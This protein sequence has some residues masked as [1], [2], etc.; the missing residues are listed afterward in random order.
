[1]KNG[2]ETCEM[3]IMLFDLEEAELLF[4]GLASA[5]SKSH[6]AKEIYCLYVFQ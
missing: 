2:M 1:M 3:G 6:A 4:C 5:P